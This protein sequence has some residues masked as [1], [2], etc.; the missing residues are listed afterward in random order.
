MTPM[1]ETEKD[2][3]KQKD[4]PCFWVGKIN[5]VKMST[6]PKA[7][8]R[9]NVIPTKIP[10]AFITELEQIIL[11][12]DWNHDRFQIVKTILR[13]NKAGDIMLLDFNYTTKLQ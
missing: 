4:I 13:K 7:T 2:T 1:K 6:L 3:N 12:F 10:M 11:K 5:V 8:Y 9:F